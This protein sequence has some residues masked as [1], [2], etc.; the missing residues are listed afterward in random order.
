MKVV[1]SLNKAPTPVPTPAPTPAAPVKKNTSK[2]IFS[3]KTAVVIIILVILIL[4][5][6]FVKYLHNKHINQ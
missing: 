5:G 1:E 6:I 4:S 3:N 2:S